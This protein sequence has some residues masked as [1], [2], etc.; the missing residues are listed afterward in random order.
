[1]IQNRVLRGILLR[2]VVATVMFAG[3]GL[4]PAAAQAPSIDPTQA[5]Q[6]FEEARKI[7]RDDGGNL[8]GRSLCGPMLFADAQTHAIVANQSDGESRLTAR[9]NVFVGTFPREINVANTAITWAG[10]RWTMVQWPLPDS[11][12]ARARR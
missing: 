10:V 7:C 6:Y 9:D 11:P 12:A 3:P 4:A 2:G 5:K 1:M 8:W